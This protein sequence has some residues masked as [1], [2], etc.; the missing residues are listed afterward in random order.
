MLTTIDNPYDPHVSYSLWRDWD[1]MSGYNTEQTLAYVY[2]SYQPDATGP[3]DDEA[4]DLA[5][6]SIILNDPLDVYIIV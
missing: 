5:I 6:Q 4:L 2:Q 1:I 3:E